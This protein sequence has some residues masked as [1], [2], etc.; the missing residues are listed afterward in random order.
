M[1][2]QISVESVFSSYNFD[3]NIIFQQIGCR[4]DKRVQLSSIKSG[5]TG[6]CKNGNKARILSKKIYFGEGRT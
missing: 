4:V 2:N 3:Q 6:I 1:A 5:I